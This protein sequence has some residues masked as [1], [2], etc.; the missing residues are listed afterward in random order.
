MRFLTGCISI[1]FVLAVVLRMRPACTVPLT[2]GRGPEP[3]RLR[4][5]RGGPGQA[6]T[7]EGRVVLDGIQLLRGAFVRL[8]SYT[9]NHAAESLLGKSKTLVDEEGGRLILRLFQE[10]RDRLV[11]YNRKDAELVLEILEHL[12]LIPL[13][14]KRSQLTGMPP[15]RVASSIAAFDY[16]YLSALHPRG[17]VAPTTRSES[18]PAGSGGHVLE[19]RAGLH[20]SVGLLD[21]KSLYPSLMRTF[22]I[23]PLGHARPGRDPIMAPNGATFSRE[24][25][26][27]PSLLDDLMPQRD[28]AKAAGDAVGSQAI[29]ILMNSFY[30][31]LGTPA[32]RFAHPD[33]ANAI[34]GL[35]RSLLLW[36]RDRLEALG[37][38]VLYGDTDSVFVHLPGTPDD[39][40][41]LGRDL[42]TRLTRELAAHIRERWEV[43]SRLEL[44]FEKLYLRLMLPPLRAGGGGARKRYAGWVYREDQEPRLEF[45]GLEAVRR[46]WTELARGLQRE[47]YRRVFAGEP[48][49]PLLRST[50]EAVRTGQRDPELVY[51]KAIRKS[52]DSYTTS[53]PP[54]VA[55]ARKR[56]KPGARTVSYVMTR[57]GPEPVERRVSPIDYEHY[58]QRQVRPIAE[59]VLHLLGETFDRAIGDDRQTDLFPDWPA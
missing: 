47:L 16:L 5:L 24:P 53:T 38:P 41:S 59:P 39:A 25:G 40:V 1:E 19:P 44:E 30:G 4:P 7:V 55:A 12:E 20:E 50:V 10:D 57:N 33:L 11:A 58:V 27:L 21:F 48:V 54:H 3:L 23:D 35:G 56:G 36:T 32:C 31:V 9:L 49:A 37:Y 42:A 51:R 2:F 13:T 14:V 22:Q 15:D 18:L 46:D 34:T 6:A 26:I 17:I 45:V 43:T 52:L 8:E 28:A 29:K